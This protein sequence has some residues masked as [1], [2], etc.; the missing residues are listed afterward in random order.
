M[1]F[2]YLFYDQKNSKNYLNFIYGN[3]DLKILGSVIE[4]LAVD[5]LVLTWTHICFWRK[6]N[7][8]RSKNLFTGK[9]VLVSTSRYYFIVYDII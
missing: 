7:P 6:H 9:L 3:F 4:E 1:E 5:F 8:T 2:G